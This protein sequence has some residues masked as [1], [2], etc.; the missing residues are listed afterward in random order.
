[1]Y[2]SKYNTI[3]NQNYNS[4]ATLNYTGGNGL[5]YTSGSTLLSTGV[6]GLTA[7]LQPG[8]LAN[9]NGTLTYSISGTP[10]SSGSASFALSFGGYAC[11]FIV[12]VYDSTHHVVS[13]NQV[14]IY[15]VVPNPVVG[16]LLSI[17][18]ISPSNDEIVNEIGRAHV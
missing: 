10:S 18:I 8:T 13:N 4:I 14:F 15:N 9:G 7:I 3:L 5:A 6:T 11:S 2:K 17:K 12:N 1:M 16:N